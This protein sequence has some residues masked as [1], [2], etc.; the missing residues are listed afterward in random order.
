MSVIQI[1]K[2]PS[3]FIYFLFIYLFIYTKM[4]TMVHTGWEG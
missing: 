1:C 4:F 3:K 2:N